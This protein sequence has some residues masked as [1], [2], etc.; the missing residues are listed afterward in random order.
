MSKLFNDHYM[1]LKY[2]P[3]KVIKDWLKGNKLVAYEAYTYAQVLKYLSR[4]GTK[5][6]KME[7]IVK[8]EY[9]LKELKNE[10]EENDTEQEKDKTIRYTFCGVT[11]FKR[12]VRK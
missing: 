2:E 9:Y 8:A 11:L 4:L 5:N 1:K 3:N 7:D 6:S 10:I 12:K